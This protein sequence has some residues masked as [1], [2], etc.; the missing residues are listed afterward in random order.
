MNNF[1]I[2]DMII[3]VSLITV[4]KIILKEFYIIQIY[5]KGV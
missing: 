5:T 2:I 1:K 4:I 3:A